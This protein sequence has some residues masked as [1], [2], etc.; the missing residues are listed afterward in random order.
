MSRSDSDATQTPERKSSSSAL[1]DAFRTLTS[2]RLQNASPTSAS[3]VA[4]L[5]H[6]PGEM[7]SIENLRPKKRQSQTS[8]ANEAHSRQE[9]E[10][11]NLAE[12]IDISI[13]KVLGGP[14][15]LHRLLHHL[16]PDQPE[17]TR[18]GS[19][20]EITL[21]LR[22]YP[23]QN[24][25]S[26]WDSGKD[27]IEE[28]KSGKESQ[29][30]YDLLEACLNRSDLTGY[31]RWHFYSSISTPLTAANLDRC[32]HIL[33][34]L[35]EQGRN[36]EGVEN[37]LP[38]QL[39]LMLKSS[40]E[41]SLAEREERKL[42]K[43]SQALKD[44]KR[45][46]I[47]QV[48]LIEE[49]T[50]YSLV[51]YVMEI[52]KYN[53]KSF[54]DD[55][56]SA[57]LT[58]LL[59]I[60]KRTRTKT[61]I[62]HSLELMTVLMTRF[63]VSIPVLS[64][65]LEVLCDIIH[66]LAELRDAAYSVIRSV[67][68]SHL[69][70][71]VTAALLALIQQSPQ[72]N[73]GITSLRGAIF[74]LHR[75]I[76][77]ESESA[78]PAVPLASV[79]RSLRSCLAFQKSS[80][81]DR[82]EADVLTFAID[83]INHPTILDVLVEEQD[84]NDL[85]SVV[86]ACLSNHSSRLR[87]KT[88]GTA[89]SER[90]SSPHSSVTADLGK[91]DDP[92]SGTSNPYERAVAS[93]LML[94][95]HVDAPIESN[96]VDVFLRSDCAHFSAEASR[97]IADYF[98]DETLLS[99]SRE[100][101]FNDTKKLVEIILKDR[102]VPNDV[103][104]RTVRTLG[105]A[106]STIEAV[107]ASETTSQ[108]ARLVIENI[109]EESDLVVQEALLDITIS[110][111]ERATDVIFQ[112][113]LQIL[114][115]SIIPQRSSS[116]IP[117][118]PGSPAFTSGPQFPNP[119][120]KTNTE[121][122]VRMFLLHLNRLAGRA[123]GLYA[124]L[125]RIARHADC[126]PDAR[127]AA[128]KLLFRIRSDASHH[129]VV[130]TSAESEHLAVSLC[131]TVDTVAT[132]KSSDEEATQRASQIL[133]EIGH[134]AMPRRASGIGTSSKSKLARR[135]SVASAVHALRPAWTYLG[136]EGLPQEPPAE[137]SPI[138]F[139]SLSRENGFDADYCEVLEIGR[140]MELVISTL[141][142]G[143]DWE[144]YSYVI[145]HVG[146]QLTNRPLFRETLPQIKHLRNVICEQVRNQTFHEPPSYT[147]LKK[148]D[149]A[150]CIFHILTMLISYHDNFSKN[151]QDEIVKMFILGI[152]ARERTARDCIHALSVCCHEMPGSVVKS[153]DQILH[154]MTQI[155]TQS[156]IAVHVLEFLA[157]VARLPDLFRNFRDEDYKMVL[158]ICFRY[159]QSVRDQR[160]RTTTPQTPVRVS[161]V[162][163]LR[164]SG[165]SRDF[166]TISEHDDHHKNSSDDL[167]QYVHALAF[168]VITF[169]FMSMKIQDRPK[170]VPYIM[171]NLSYT[172]QWGKTTVEEQGEVT[173][174][175]IERVAYSDRDETAPDL[176]FAKESD[177]QISKRTWLIGNS[178]LTIDTAGRSG[179]SQI[180][181]RRPSYTRY[182]L[183]KPHL[184]DP[185]QHQVPLALGVRA[186]IYHTSDFVGIYPEDVMQEFYAPISMLSHGS[187]AGQPI[188]LQDEEYINRALSTFDR[189]PALDSHKIGVIYMDVGQ[190][191]E[192]DILAN[193]G[194]AADYNAFL[195]G[196]GTLTRLRGS[197]LN[198]HGLDRSTDTDGIYT[199]CWRDRVTEI[200]YH[201]TTLMPNYP[202][203]DPR[204]Y[205][206]K[207]HVGNDFVNII[208]NASG[209]RFHPESTIPSQ[210]TT[211]YIVITPEAHT[212]FRHSV[213][214]SNADHLDPDISV[215]LSYKVQVLT[216]SG[217]PATSPATETK[218][219]SGAA[220]P[221]FIRLLALNASVLSSVWTTRDPSG[222]N[223]DTYVSSWRARLRV[224]K[225]LRE[226]VIG[227]REEVVTE[228][229]RSVVEG[230]GNWR[231]SVS[232]AFGRPGEG[233]EREWGTG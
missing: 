95:A 78:F 1:L 203:D 59:N 25:L 12:D 29:A 24:V 232:G 134:A 38:S 186:E 77:S 75:A 61:D 146:A 103:R 90:Y 183:Y 51:R 36:I 148:S 174:D 27:L 205:Q 105:K 178:L 156:N 131:R 11:T 76:L 70:H 66:Q 22:E 149:V 217:F 164:H 169:W 167:P 52:T 97:F 211:V 91:L 122:V 108:F 190:T 58:T 161:Q 230:G 114:E 202:L 69:G 128:L 191:A 34:S 67:L 39:A 125:L 137:P 10:S 41:K 193:T 181:R 89:S 87:A 155:I 5:A 130:N 49:K 102:S 88:R 233:A 201:V 7:S 140:L 227:E 18:V 30:G 182:S 35:T 43:K 19:A 177:G 166:A 133:E 71:A 176:G 208:W 9:E 84:L 121:C 48:P 68:R 180:T 154:K 21:I 81:V 50:L 210:L 2:S 170:H 111:A 80:K 17:Q 224:I 99:P 138:L 79:L 129:I 107:A 171:A 179:L 225:Q 104:L 189:I 124:L 53:A 74:V 163:T 215:S 153:M 47:T 218:I 157:A 45:A 132:L 116:Y 228:R 115:A 100:N 86:E 185:P 209:R 117:P 65:C 56:V 127:L 168:H 98:S 120:G 136:P 187:T 213:H 192:R 15:R 126:E 55:D 40:F 37:L 31:E 207:M 44:G 16:G 206:K 6:S 92:L 173:M 196:L 144:V 214:F 94:S 204:H 147:G 42:S 83:L 199:Y 226:R 135:S 112:T 110:V 13:G 33:E 220:L 159:L 194:G 198:M 123:K 4:T 46:P 223:T 26:I 152:G 8:D 219:V 106:Y 57:L 188:L 72:S 216:K 85:L 165:A 113:I 172:N 151:E 23:I 64:S 109:I 184:I 118:L 195:N 82:L 212:S 32:L 14:P 93:L 73:V 54:L 145:V 221:S 96:I 175:M 139:S 158:G 200:I 197:T 143:A 222:N 142:Q 62:T 229:R 119:L 160:E 20:K 150:I 3:S 231:S 63:Y 60:C 162:S 141:Q 101:W 28:G